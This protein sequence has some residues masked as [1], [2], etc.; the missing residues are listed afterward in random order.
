LKSYDNESEIVQMVN[1]AIPRTVPEHM[2]ADI[3][4]DAMVAILECRVEQTAI[5]LKPFLRKWYKENV[6]GFRPL[7]LDGPSRYREGE[8][9]GQEMG[10]Y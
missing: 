1:D 9:L 7:S 5:T 8:T 2:R 10:I 3:C 4:Q 6:D